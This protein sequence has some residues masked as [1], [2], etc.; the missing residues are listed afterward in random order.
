M[1]ERSQFLQGILYTTP[2]FLMAGSVSFTLM[3]CW[4]SVLVVV[5]T[6]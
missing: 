6:V 3:S 4:P 1:Y 5:N 2:D